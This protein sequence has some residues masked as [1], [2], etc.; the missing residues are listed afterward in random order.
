M[1]RSRY[2][3]DSCPWYFSDSYT[4][5]YGCVLFGEDCR[6]NRQMEGDVCYVHPRRLQWIAQQRN[7]Q[8]RVM[9]RRVNKRY[10]PRL[11][12][13][14][15]SKEYAEGHGYLVVAQGVDWIPTTYSRFYR[16]CRK[17]GHHHRRNY[18]QCSQCAKWFRNNK[19]EHDVIKLLKVRVHFCSYLCSQA[20]SHEADRETGWPYE[21]HHVIEDDII[22]DG[23]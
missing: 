6:K 3:D 9:N 15:T 1:K 17:G 20:A 4:E 14:T 21:P 8:D 18:S 13:P 7:R 11:K 16:P 22:K 5:S 12:S 10:N 19:G 2:C 23:K